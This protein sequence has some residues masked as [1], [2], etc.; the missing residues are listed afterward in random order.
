M[1]DNDLRSIVEQVVRGVLDRNP[2]AAP[3]PTTCGEL[4][5][6]IDHTQLK[7]AATQAEVAKLCD[8]AA[9]HGFYSVCVNSS[10][11]PFCARRLAGTGVTVCSVVGFPLGAMSTAAKAFETSDAVANGAGEIDMVVNVGRLKSGDFPFVQSDIRA[12]VEAAAGKPV[13]VIIETCFLTDDEKIAACVMAK[14][15]GAAFV[16]TSTGFGTGGATEADLALMR[17]V[18][19]PE[20]G[21]K[22]SGGIRDC[23]SALRMVAAEADRLGVSASVAIISGKDG[24]SGY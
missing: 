7:A 2:A 16:K 5:S 20:M 17:R 18:V 4:A 13:K 1:S 6:M 21:V 9:K 19:G 11:V 3:V 24:K 22:A 12:V 8:E 23:P 15:A 14:A 10:W